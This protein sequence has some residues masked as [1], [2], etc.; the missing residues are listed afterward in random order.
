MG[1][2]Y[3]LLDY[4]YREYTCTTGAAVPWCSGETPNAYHASYV[5]LEKEQNVSS[6]PIRK[7]SVLWR[8][9]VTGRYS[10]L[11]IRP[12]T[13]RKFLILCSESSDSFIHSVLLSGI[14]AN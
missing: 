5:Q 1:L 2:L 6:L 3:K 4:L 14:G 7:D 13:G 11:G 8:A 9:S 12:P 10:L